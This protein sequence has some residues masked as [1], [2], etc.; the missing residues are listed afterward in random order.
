MKK[1]ILFI[2]ITFSLSIYAQKRDDLYEYT[3]IS[4]IK[5][6]KSSN[7]DY[8]DDKIDVHF[9]PKYKYDGYYFIG[10]TVKN[11]TSQRFY[12]EWDNARICGSK[13]I[14]NDDRMLFMNNKKDDEAVACDEE[15][16]EKQIMPKENVLK[17]SVSA[18][19]ETKSSGEREIPII[20]PIRFSEEVIDYKFSWLFSKYSETEIDSMYAERQK[21]YNLSKLVKKKMTIE[22]VKEIMGEFEDGSYI[23]RNGEK[24]YFSLA[25]PGISIDLDR[26]GLVTKI[27]KY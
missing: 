16:E 19:Y 27:S 3:K 5:P 13:A 1:N 11:K 2:C 9:S 21:Y 6:I 24:K 17:Y 18:L 26:D 20:L 23:I 15:S 14:F 7:L 4:L 12:I 10:I 8:S 22:Q 25:Y